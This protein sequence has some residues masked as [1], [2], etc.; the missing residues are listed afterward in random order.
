MIGVV[1]RKKQKCDS[2]IMEEFQFYIISGMKLNYNVSG[3]Y[4][5]GKNFLKTQI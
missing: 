4:E 2:Y 5:N 1:I 3:Y